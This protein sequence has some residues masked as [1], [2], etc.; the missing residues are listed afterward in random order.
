MPD[1][2][3][4]HSPVIT[5]SVVPKRFKELLMLH[6][7]LS[8]RSAAASY[9]VSSVNR[10]NVPISRIREPE[11]KLNLIIIGNLITPEVVNGQA[12][13]RTLMYW[14]QLSHFP[15]PHTVQHKR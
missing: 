14:F 7:F 5:S 13:H 15:S 11:K 1:E 12:S 6:N 8:A 9:L 4:I 10:D 2:Y 3:S